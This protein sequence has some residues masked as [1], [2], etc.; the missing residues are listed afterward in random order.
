VHKERKERKKYTFKNKDRAVGEAQVS[1][2]RLS[3]GGEQISDEQRV[4]VSLYVSV[5]V[6]VSLSV[7]GA[8][9]CDCGWRLGS[10]WILTVGEV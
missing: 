5:S 1:E 9:G 3:A 4:S 7:S 10:V 2:V 8:A 6:C